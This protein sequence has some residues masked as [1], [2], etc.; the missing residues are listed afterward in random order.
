MNCCLYMPSKPQM[1]KSNNCKILHGR[2]RVKRFHITI[3]KSVICHTFFKSV[4]TLN[5]IRPSVHP[6]FTRTLPFTRTIEPLEEGLLNFT[7]YI[8][9][10]KLF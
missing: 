8:P 1:N 5:P 10:D 6:S 9:C 4:G 2:E 7:L 3:F